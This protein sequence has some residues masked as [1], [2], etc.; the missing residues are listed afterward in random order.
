MDELLH[1]FCRGSYGGGRKRAMHAS[2]E[3][4][5]CVSVLVFEKN[6]TLVFKFLLLLNQ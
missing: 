1:L 2:E 3:K 4:C 6:T 5:F